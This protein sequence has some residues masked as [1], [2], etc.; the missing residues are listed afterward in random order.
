MRG[1]LWVAVLALLGWSGWWWFASD[2]ADKAARG[3]FAARQA[4]GWQAS[5]DGIAVQGF[6]NRIDL[7]ITRP[8][9]APPTG[10]WRWQ[11]PFVQVLSLSYKPWHLIAAFANDQRLDTP[12]GPLTLTSDKL[13]ASLVLVPGPDLALDRSQ[14]AGSG[15]R[16]DGLADLGIAQLSVATRPAVGLALAHDLG[17]EAQ[18]ISPPAA[19]MATLPPGTLPAQIPL[20]RLDATLTL[21]APLDRHA[22]RT[23][24]QL[25]RLTLREARLDWGDIRAHVSGELTPDADGLAQGRLDVRLDGAAKA[26]D[27]AIAAGLIAPEARATWQA[28]IA[29]LAP[30]GQSLTLPLQLAGGR[31]LMGP[32]PLGPAPRLR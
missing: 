11:T 23:R 24:P 20:V 26:L 15:L 4:E 10:D 31:M 17:I 12:A 19:L 32:L 7:T 16:L 18:G 30:P 2:T 6:P 3:W 25:D 22:A 27:L 29:T 13:Q 1:L 8:D 28:A 5:H 14:L 9:I 21:T